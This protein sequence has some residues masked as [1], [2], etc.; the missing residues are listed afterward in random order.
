MSVPHT[1]PD[2]K[3][4]FAFTDVFGMSQK[5]HENTI[6]AIT[7]GDKSS[8]NWMAGDRISK[9]RMRLTP[10]ETNRLIPAESSI[11]TGMKRNIT[12]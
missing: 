8:R 1:I 7:I 6:Q 9:L 2:T 11:N 5:A 12:V 3:A 4:G 10:A